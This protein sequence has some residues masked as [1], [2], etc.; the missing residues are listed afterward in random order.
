MMMAFVRMY[1]Y[2]ICFDSDIISR[3]EDQSEEH[4]PETNVAAISD[5]HNSIAFGKPQ[6]TNLEEIETSERRN[7]QFKSA[8]AFP[9]HAIVLLRPCPKW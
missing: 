8:M 4:I 7:F 3:M 9:V 2:L 5:V 6:D 1:Y